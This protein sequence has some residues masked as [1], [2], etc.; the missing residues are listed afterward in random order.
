MDAAVLALLLVT[1]PLVLYQVCAF[2]FFEHLELLFD[3]A[4]LILEKLDLELVDLTLLV[5][6]NVVEFALLKVKLRV[7]VD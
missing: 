4:L 7:L 5:L 3:S 1:N 2:L 6:V